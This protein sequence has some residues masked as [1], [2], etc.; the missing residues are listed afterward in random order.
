MV[1]V[2][3]GDTLLLL[4]DDP[5]IE[6]DLAAWCHETGNELV[7]LTRQDGDYRGLVRR[8]R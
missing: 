5:L 1:G 8:S 6:M 2:H 3:V 7:E 4:A